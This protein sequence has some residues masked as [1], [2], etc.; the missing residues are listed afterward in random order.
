MAL[1]T[2]HDRDIELADSTAARGTLGR[3][4]RSD[5][6]D[7]WRLVARW[8]VK[9]AHHW[10]RRPQLL[11]DLLKFGVLHRAHQEATK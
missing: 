6:R 2:A 3:V 8:P 1:S 4:G 10:Y 5:G 9:G 11:I 7:R